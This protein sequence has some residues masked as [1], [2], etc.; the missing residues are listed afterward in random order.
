VQTW[1]G[2]KGQEKGRHET[3]M[4]LGA[5]AGKGDGTCA[6]RGEKVSTYSVFGGVRKLEGIGRERKN[7]SGV[8][9][10]FNVKKRI[11]LRSRKERMDRRSEEG[12]CIPILL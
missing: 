6:G 5:K 2:E 4:K 7:L 3:K 9:K 12:R 1:G 10:Q 8:K 11:S